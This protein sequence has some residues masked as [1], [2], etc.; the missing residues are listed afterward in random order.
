MVVG[1]VAYGVSAS[2]NLLHQ[3]GVELGIVAQTKKCRL[4]TILVEDVENLLGDFGRRAVVESEIDTLL[5]V[6]LPQHC[7]HHTPYELRKVEIH[8]SRYYSSWWRKGIK[9]FVSLYP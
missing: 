3:L 8:F 2:H 9:F 1:V 7:G 5:A 6:D 4:G